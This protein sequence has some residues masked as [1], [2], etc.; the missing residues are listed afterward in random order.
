MVT[1]TRSLL[2]VSKSYFFSSD[3]FSGVRLF[4]YRCCRLSDN[5]I[6]VRPVTG[7]VRPVTGRITSEDNCP[8]AGQIASQ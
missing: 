2:A 6:P 8:V 5:F 3:V 7:R 4:A 1:P